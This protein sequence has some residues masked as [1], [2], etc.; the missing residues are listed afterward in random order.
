MGQMA[1]ATTKHHWIPHNI[2]LWIPET[3][4]VSDATVTGTWDKKGGI[5]VQVLSQG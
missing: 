4:M 1:A 2:P 5:I 3:W